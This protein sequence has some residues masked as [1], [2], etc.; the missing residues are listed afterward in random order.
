[1]VT[2]GAMMLGLAGVA[3]ASA[4]EQ[5]DH[6]ALRVDGF[7]SSDADGAELTRFGVGWDVQ[8]RDREHWIGAKVEQARFVAPGWSHEEQRVYFQAAGTLG[9]GDVDDDTWRWRVSPGTNGDQLLGSAA[10]NTEGPR[11]RELFIERE[12]LETQ[13]GVEREQVVTFLGAAIDHP[14]GERA[15]V[16]GLAGWQDFD[17]SNRRVHLRANGVVSVWRE[18]GLSLQLRTRYYR[19]SEPNLGDYFSPAWYVDV[20]PA[21]GWRRFVSGH[22]FNAV[23]GVGRQRTAVE[24][25]RRARLLQA[26]YESPRWRDSWVRVNVGY[27]DT[28]VATSAQRDRYSYRFVMFEGVIAF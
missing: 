14:L 25:S 13:Q 4:A 26:G 2:L 8:R 23:A 7:H 28:P 20:I 22:Q 17:D 21:I 19:N 11:R 18:Q 15:S 12:L 10:M 27:S 16:T 5:G 9:S 24:D 6:Q 3:G 1:M